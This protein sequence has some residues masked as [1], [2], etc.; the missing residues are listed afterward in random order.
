M[1]DK[2]EEE[3][4][5]ARHKKCIPAHLCEARQLAS[6]APARR[7][8]ALTALVPPPVLRLTV[9]AALRG[10]A[11]ARAALERAPAVAVAR[12]ATGPRAQAAALAGGDA[13][14]AQRAVRARR[15][16][17]VETRAVQ[18]EQLNQ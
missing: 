15:R 5:H 1:Q 6:F 14:L 9:C 2:E 3:E 4:N 10:D 17:R 8:Y 18:R 12:A 7:D 11:A 16:R 13:R